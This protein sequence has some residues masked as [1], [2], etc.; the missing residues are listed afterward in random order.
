MSPPIVLLAY[1]I[2]KNQAATVAAQI[3]KFSSLV[4]D[5]GEL[6]LL[7]LRVA[8]DVVT[9]GGTYLERS[10]TL[11]E[12]V[13]GFANAFGASE[14]PTTWNLKTLWGT[15]IEKA[16]QTSLLPVP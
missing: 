15:R 12:E 5:Q 14:D 6:Q 9:D 4:L 13:P 7:Q 11:S 2:P 1:R 16:L 10:L 8:S 3:A